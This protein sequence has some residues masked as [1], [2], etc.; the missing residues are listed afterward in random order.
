MSLTNPRYHGRFY[1]GVPY[2]SKIS[3]YILK[4]CPIQI[5]DIKVHFT[6]VSYTNPRS[7]GRF[8]R[9]ALEWGCVYTKQYIKQSVIENMG[10]PRN[11][12]SKFDAA[13]GSF[14]VF[15]ENLSSRFHFIL[16]I[17]L[18]Y[19]FRNM[20][21]GK[22]KERDKRRKEDTSGGEGGGGKRKTTKGKIKYFGRKI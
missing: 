22:G 20:I 13:N 1:R 12:S 9:K 8:Y 18:F 16:Q 6:W 15:L 11:G 7:H 5:L 19:S 10:C 17:F 2:K 4:W 21:R 3:R 14:H